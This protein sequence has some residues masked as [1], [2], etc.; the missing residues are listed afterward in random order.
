MNYDQIKTQLLSLQSTF[1]HLE[2]V[3]VSLLSQ[4]IKTINKDVWFIDEE[5]RNDLVNL[6]V[7]LNN[8]HPSHSCLLVM[9]NYNFEDNIDSKEFREL[10]CGI[11]K[12]GMIII[13]DTDGNNNGVITGFRKVIPDFCEATTRALDIIQNNLL[14]IFANNKIE[15]EIL[16]QRMY[17]AAEKC[18]FLPTTPNS[19]SFHSEHLSEDDIVNKI[20]IIRWGW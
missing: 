10:I 20:K 16:R 1:S 18:E 6:K 2:D 7:T 19:S 15:E 9:P 12:D 3:K 17:E 5:D 8:I 14:K 13:A 4:L 11:S